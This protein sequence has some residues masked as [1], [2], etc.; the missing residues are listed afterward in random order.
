MFW[1][2]RFFVDGVGN[3]FGLATIFS[4]QNLRYSTFGQFQLYALTIIIGIGVLLLLL[5]KPTF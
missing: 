1:F 5:S 4:G 3:F 2:D